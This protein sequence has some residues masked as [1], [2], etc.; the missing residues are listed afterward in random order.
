MDSIMVCG[1]RPLYGETRI[2]GS[3]NAALPI[4]AATVLVKGKTRLYRCP[5]I[6]DIIY[7]LHILREIGCTVFWEDEDVLVIDAADCDGYEIAEQYAGKMRSSIILLGSVLGRNGRVQVP[8][9]GGCIIGKRP[10]DMHIAA[11]QTMNV[12]IETHE[13]TLSAQ[14]SGLT[15]ATLDLALPSVGTTENIILAAV[16]ARGRTRINGAARE[17][18]IAALCD[19]LNHAGAR[20]TGAGTET[21]EINGVRRLQQTTYEIPA[22]RIVAGT[23]SLATVATRGSTILYDAPIHQMDAFIKIIQSMGA[24]VSRIRHADRIGLVIDAEQAVHAV[25]YLET[26]EYPGFPTD[27]QSQLMTVLTTADGTSRILETIFEERYKIVGELQKMGAHITIQDREAVIESVPRLQ[28]T[29]LQASELRGGAALV[30]AGLMAQQTTIVEN[31]HF[32]KRGHED[33]VKDLKELS[34]SIKYL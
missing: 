26:K 18:E 15:G 29:T 23:Y 11:L 13:K 8:Y 4:L 3:K 17:P 30:I 5:K 27:L 32:I 1:G 28:G 22:D 20:I 21:I 14:T 19:Y 25:E 34:A 9:P 31:A 24:R 6:L 16:T 12:H 10:I 2:Q 7:M 33:I